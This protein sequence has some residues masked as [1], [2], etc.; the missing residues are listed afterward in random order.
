MTIPVSLNVPKII[1][2]Q[3]TTT[4]KIPKLASANYVMRVVGF[5]MT[6]RT[7]LAQ[8]VCQDSILTSKIIFALKIVL[9]RPTNQQMGLTYANLA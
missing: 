9:I 4:L 8:S 6:Q 5:A 3:Q 7:P 1:A 2:M